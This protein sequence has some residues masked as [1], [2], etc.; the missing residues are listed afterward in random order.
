ME[1]HVPDYEWNMH[2][3]SPEE[4]VEIGAGFGDYKEGGEFKLV[5]LQVG[6]ITTYRIVGG[7]PVPVMIGFPTG[8]DAEP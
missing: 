5:R 1:I 3:K 8:I 4:A 2:Y 6:A 7:K